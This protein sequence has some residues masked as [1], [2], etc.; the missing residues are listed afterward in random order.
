MLTKEPYNSH[1]YH[2]QLQDY[3]QN[4]HKNY[5]C[6]SFTVYILFTELTLQAS[7]S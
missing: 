3:S 6:Y 2:V 5:T 4:Q 7:L 1:H